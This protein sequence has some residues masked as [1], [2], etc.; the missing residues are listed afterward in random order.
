MSQE[1]LIKQHL[2]RAQNHIN[3]LEEALKLKDE[4][5]TA[6]QEIIDELQKQNEGLKSIIRGDI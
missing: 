5:L 1:D 6:R 2:D 3:A 4:Q